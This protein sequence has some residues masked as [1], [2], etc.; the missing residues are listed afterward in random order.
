MDNSGCVRRLD[1]S[2]RN[3]SVFCGQ[4]LG[5]AAQ[6]CRPYEAAAPGWERGSLG[7][8][9]GALDLRRDRSASYRIWL[10]V[11]WPARSRRGQCWTAGRVCTFFSVRN[12]P[13]EESRSPC[14]ARAR[15]ELGKRGLLSNLQSRSRSHR[16][17]R[18]ATLLSASVSSSTRNSLHST[19]ALRAR[20]SLSQRRRTARV[21]Y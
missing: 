3:C 21:T 18:A 19:S 16:R 2:C 15:G 1:D 9:R 13:P 14:V 17:Q 8:Y 12:D 20:T 11:G 6:R 4:K 5:N 10:G 7:S